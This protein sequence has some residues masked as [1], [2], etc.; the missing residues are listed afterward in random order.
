MPIDLVP[1]KT[2]VASASPPEE[3]PSSVRCRAI[4][5]PALSGRMPA[6][7]LGLTDPDAHVRL[8]AAAQ[9]ARLLESKFSEGG[10]AP[11]VGWLMEAVR[12]PRLFF[13]A[14]DPRLQSHESFD[15]QRALHIA[16]LSGLM[17]VQAIMQRQE[18]PL[19]IPLATYFRH[20]GLFDHL[21]EARESD[22][23]LRVCFQSGLTLPPFDIERGG[24]IE[25]LMHTFKYA[26]AVGAYQH[27][28]LRA[29]LFPRVSE[30]RPEP[31][32]ALSTRMGI[33]NTLGHIGRTA[34]EGESDP[35]VARQLGDELMAVV[36]VFVSL[37][38]PRHAASR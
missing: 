36:G 21:K 9:M 37:R 7:Q 14:R 34:V 6:L 10:L 2:I 22:R 27:R 16:R 26:V 28:E 25:Y 11:V 19:R 33:L 13:K 35:V 20:Q 30:R 5:S 8:V 24:E 18:S 32:S 4:R 31:L 17:V 15:P 38:L 23:F 29:K 1:R 3:A 12:E